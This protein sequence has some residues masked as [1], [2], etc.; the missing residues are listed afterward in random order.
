MRQVHN[1][2]HVYIHAMNVKILITIV[3]HAPI[4]LIE[5]QFRTVAV[6]MVI[7]LKKVILS[8]MFYFLLSTNILYHN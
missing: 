8:N 7:F 3:K 2:L 1:V 6:L 5:T 4:Y